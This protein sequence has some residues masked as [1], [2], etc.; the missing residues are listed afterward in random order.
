MKT[1]L[2]TGIVFQALWIAAFGSSTTTF[3]Q[4]PSQS[5]SQ[6]GSP[7]ATGA[8]TGGLNSDMKLEDLVK[9]SVVVPALGTVVNTVSRQES[10]VGRSPAAIFVI[11]PEMIKRSGVRSIP[12]ALRMAPGIDVARINADTWAISARGFNGR[13]AD[14][15]LV[16]IDRRVVYT[17]T[18]NGVYWNMQDVV[19]ADIDR[20]EVIRGPGT[21]AW[22][23]NAVN[24]V[25][26]IITKKSSD[27]QGVLIQSGGGNQEQNFNTLRY[28]GK[29]GEDLTW[30]VY[31][32]QFDRNSGW[33]NGSSNDSW[34]Q[35]RAG[36]RADYTPTK[37]ET[38]TLQGDIFN[39]YA[40][41][42]VVTAIPF[43][44]F[45][46]LVNDRTH[47][48]GGNVLCR[49]GQ[50]IDSD[51]SWQIQSYFDRYQNNS[52]IFAETRNTYDVDFQY[53]FSPAEFHQIV[54]GG[55]YRRSQDFTTG[56]FALSLVPP[57]FATQWAS[58]FAQDT[59][60]LVE[61][62]LYFTL[63][64]RLEQNTF[65]HFQVEPTA[66]L[67][68]LPSPRQSAWIAVSRA[69]RNPARDDRGLISNTNAIPGQPVFSSV[70]GNPSFPVSSLIA[71]EVGYRAAP[72][73][74]FSW[75]IAGFINDYH[76]VEGE[77]AP[78]APIVIPP[79]LILIP[80]LKVGNL[81][82]ISY[83]FETTATYRLTMQWR[84]FCSYS[85]FE[86][87]ARGDNPVSAAN[88]N[89]SSPHN[90]AYL[91]S[92]WDLGSNVQ[93]DLIGRYVDRLTAL[94]VP[95]YIEMDARLGWQIRKNLEFSF[96]GQNLLN[97]HHLEFVDA[98]SNLVSTQV[99]RGGY[100]MVSW[101]Y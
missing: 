70:I 96:V 5:A 29:A 67:L 3:G 24:G 52:A 50:V 83:G 53:Q 25:I 17:P 38:V 99:R 60:T 92:S 94:G 21:T 47:F 93:F 12:E 66:R 57:N 61:D 36:F 72:T 71:Y 44:P 13:F 95:Q 101:T 22:G 85:L 1:M 39:G 7:A 63:G 82:A 27:T 79:G 20:I 75:D 37:Q 46:K 90:Q 74:D 19:L 65:G 56:T 31:G 51:T 16:Q 88:L 34:R 64:T 42:S 40:G 6:A 49:Y 80:S 28:G 15:L 87:Q 33:N 91:R 100:A 43:S 2:P 68:F 55:F 26:N 32:Q 48:P 41:E 73:D 86:I 59:M 18:N 89:G 54:T 14:K 69:I 4:N 97:S 84:L 45:Q 9:Q 11:T 98:E 10:T 81:R 23:S 78:G 62:R 8:V 35:Q 30:R 58:V 77:T 76:K